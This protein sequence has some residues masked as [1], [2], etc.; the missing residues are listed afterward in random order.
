MDE[1]Q[2]V[3]G[4]ENTGG[5]RQTMPPLQKLRQDYTK[6]SDHLNELLEI[7]VEIATIFDLK[8]W[9]HDAKKGVNI[10]SRLCKVLANSLVKNGVT[11]EASEWCQDF[12]TSKNY[13]DM[14]HSLVTKT[15]EDRGEVPSIVD[16][17]TVAGS[18]REWLEKYHTDPN[19]VVSDQGDKETQVSATTNVI[20]S[21]HAITVVTAVPLSTTATYTNAVMTPS[22]GV[23]YSSGVQ[24]QPVVP[25]L[26]T[27]IGGTHFVNTGS[28]TALPAQHT[29]TGGGWYNQM[30]RREMIKESVFVF[31][32]KAA[33]FTAWRHTST[34][35]T[36]QAGMDPL[37]TLRFMVSRS[38]G[39]PQNYLRTEVRFCEIGE[40][41][42]LDKI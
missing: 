9:R 18:V 39:D 14:K 1:G 8:Q 11:Q 7:D 4:G 25:N 35:H 24:S 10:L 21:S 17:S 28:R 22:V 42:D 38:I 29:N 6:Q 36:Q 15:L 34:R 41:V 33:D 5:R 2:S 40:P 32:G 3:F 31:K 20:T 13:Y 12:S 19:T 27:N 23:N 16:G 30:S 26:P 37:E